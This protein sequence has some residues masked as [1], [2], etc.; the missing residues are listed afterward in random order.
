MFYPMLAKIVFKFIWSVLVSIIKWNFLSIGMLGSH[1]ILTVIFFYNCYCSNKGWIKSE[2]DVQ[3]LFFILLGLVYYPWSY[4]YDELEFS[5]SSFCGVDFLCSCIYWTTIIFYVIFSMN[6]SIPCP[7]NCNML[8]SID[9]AR[10][11]CNFLGFF[12]PMLF[13]GMLKIFSCNLV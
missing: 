4:A 1:F 12:F 11:C 8:G 9:Y 13:Y 2:F 7:S 5:M 6:T 10:S 3:N